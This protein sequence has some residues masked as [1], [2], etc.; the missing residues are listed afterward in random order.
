MLY[1]MKWAHAG[2]K[3][4]KR[5]KEVRITGNRMNCALK[6]LDSAVSSPPGC[7]KNEV[8]EFLMDNE[9]QRMGGIVWQPS[10]PKVTV[11]KNVWEFK[12]D[13]GNS[14]E[15]GYKTIVDNYFSNI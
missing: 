8:H 14:D 4:K 15:I 9:H 13:H 12:A 10:K 6:W 5:E 7:I 2:S 11:N 1:A 3:E